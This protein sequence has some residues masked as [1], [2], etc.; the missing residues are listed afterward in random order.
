M[1]VN[2][3]TKFQFPEFS[4]L[5]AVRFLGKERPR[6]NRETNLMHEIGFSILVIGGSAP[7]PAGASRN[8]A[9]PPPTNPGRG[10]IFCAKPESTGAPR[11]ATDR[12]FRA[13]LFHSAAK[14]GQAF[15]D[16]LDRAGVGEAQIA[17]RSEG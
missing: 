1:S 16:G 9:P 17:R 12:L 3:P 5:L 15:V 14:G 4:S 6:D 8:G 11:E 13:E 2:E 10:R 7:A